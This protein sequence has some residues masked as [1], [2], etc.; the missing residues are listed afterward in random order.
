MPF[1]LYHQS[2]HTL[3]VLVVG[4]LQMKSGELV[5]AEY[6]NT[7]NGHACPLCVT[8]EAR[9]MYMVALDDFI[10]DILLFPIASLAFLAN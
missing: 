7:S 8:L 1:R 4:T 9:C 6:A 5:L 3:V 10:F 2:L